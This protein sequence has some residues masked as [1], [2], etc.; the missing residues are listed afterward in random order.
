MPPCLT[1]IYTKSRV[2]SFLRYPVFVTV[3]L[4][5]PSWSFQ[6]SLNL[7]GSLGWLW[8]SLMSMPWTISQM[9]T[10]P[11]VLSFTCFII[12][13]VDMIYSIAYLFCLSVLNCGL[14]SWILLLLLPLS[15]VSISLN[16][17]FP[18]IWKQPPLLF[19]SPW[20]RNLTHPSM[21]RHET[22]GQRLKGRRQSR[23]LLLGPFQT[24]INWWV[25]WLLI[26]CVCVNYFFLAWQDCEAR[27]KETWHLC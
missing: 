1:P 24:W 18:S 6:F 17:L 26:S 22:L 15:V 14:L 16:H 3:G 27:R 21:P 7:R 10:K 4:L 12:H 2:L 5:D 19:L 9:G 23:C 20:P 25:V 13:T 8:I 11:S